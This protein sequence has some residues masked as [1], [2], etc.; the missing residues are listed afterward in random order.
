MEGVRALS[1]VPFI[2]VL[3]PKSPPPNTITLGVQFQHM[4]SGGTRNMASMS[5]L[6]LWRTLTDAQ[7][8]PLPWLHPPSLLAF[9]DALGTDPFEKMM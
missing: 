3:I 2:R 9:L 1:G 4:K 5:V 8:H 7:T 6:L